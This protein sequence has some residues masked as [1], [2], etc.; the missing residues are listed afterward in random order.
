AGALGAGLAVFFYYSA[1]TFIPIFARRLSPPP[2]LTPADT[3]R[4]P[5][6]LRLWG[7]L[8]DAVSPQGKLPPL[9]VLLGLIALVDH[10]FWTQNLKSKIQNPK[11]G[12]G[13]LLLSWWLGTL[14]SLGLLLFAGQGVRWQHFLYPALCLG[15]GPVLAHLWRRGGAGRAVAL[16]GALA[17]VCYGLV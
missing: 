14:L 1:S 2:G 15:A 17:P 10:G 6:L 8:L 4:P 7:A 11:S 3:A 13:L 5:D 16:A 12:L 9:L